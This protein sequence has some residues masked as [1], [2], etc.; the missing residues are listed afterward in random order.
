MVSTVERMKRLLQRDLVTELERVKINKIAKIKQYPYLSQRK[1]YRH[2][3]VLK[4]V[5]GDLLVERDILDGCSE[6]TITL[7]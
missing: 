3:T 4:T 5:R 7:R 6:K 1:V 2:L